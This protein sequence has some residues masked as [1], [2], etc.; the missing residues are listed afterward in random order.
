MITFIYT[1]TSILVYVSNLPRLCLYCSAQL[2]IENI[3]PNTY[4]YN[5]QYISKLDNSVY[6]EYGIGI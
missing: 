4:A 2:R 5:V 3:S 1:A 6:L